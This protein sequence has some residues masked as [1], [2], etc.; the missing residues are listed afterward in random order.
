[1]RNAIQS[2][3][4][5]LSLMLLAGAPSA[6]LAEPVGFFTKVQGDVDILPAG[7]VVQPARPGG[8]VSL[9]DAV[10]TKRNGKTEI[11]FKDDTMIQLAPETRITID[12][13]SFRGADTRETG[14]LSLLRGKLRAVVSR[15]RAV[16]VPVGRAESS[17][18]IK[19]PTAIA[20]VKGSDLIV[21]HERGI[22]GV[23]FIEGLGFVFNPSLP[24]RVVP[25]QGG[26]MSLVRS[27][28]DPPL[29]AVNVSGAFSDP[30]IRDT[31]ID[32]GGPAGPQDGDGDVNVFAANTTY[33][34]ITQLAGDGPLG[35]APAPRGPS[36]QTGDPTASL[37]TNPATQIPITVTQPALL[38]TPVTVNV[39]M[40]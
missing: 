5:I 2:T 7:G 26:Q 25:I 20:G 4:L 30:H 37:P 8:P 19:T 40:P 24:D 28:A 10:R 22:T 23:V 18:N 35:G 34:A 27:A 17:F 3:L 11:Q 13:Y 21:Y 15:I 6:A 39:T 32:G 16:A 38:R 31:A 33:E 9:G 36:L 29:D 12:E 14:L 1:M